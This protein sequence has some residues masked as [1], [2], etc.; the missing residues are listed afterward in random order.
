MEKEKPLSLCDLGFF[1][2][3]GKKAAPSTTVIPAKAGIHF[4]RP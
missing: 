3:I 1:I 2:A 4:Q